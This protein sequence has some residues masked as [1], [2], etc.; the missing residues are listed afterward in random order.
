L[1]QDPADAPIP[2]KE[3]EAR[4]R[5]LVDDGEE[6]PMRAGLKTGLKTAFVLIVS[7]L[8]AHA[9]Y[10]CHGCNGSPPQAPHAQ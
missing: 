2:S 7:G 5:A 6:S 10:D 4:Y 9:C 3:L 1:E 8:T